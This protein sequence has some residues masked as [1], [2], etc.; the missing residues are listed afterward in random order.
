VIY[1]LRVI[2]KMYMEDGRGEGKSFG[3]APYLYIAIGLAVIG[4][5]YL[6]VL[7]ASALEWS[8]LALLSLY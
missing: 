7:P 8:G 2:V 4:N 1:Y 5:I 6:G 3:Q